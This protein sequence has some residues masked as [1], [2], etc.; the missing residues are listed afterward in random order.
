MN[1]R[2]LFDDYK[3]TESKPS[4]VYHTQKQLKQKGGITPAPCER[5]KKMFR[6]LLVNRFFGRLCC[7]C[8]IKILGAE[9]YDYDVRECPKQLLA[10][11]WNPVW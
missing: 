6:F 10:M 3:T 2:E 1:W 7:S 8:Y 9:K 11:G 5:C 4:Q